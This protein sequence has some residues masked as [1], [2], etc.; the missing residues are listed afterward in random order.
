MVLGSKARLTSLPHPQ[1]DGN[2]GVA[3]YESPSA[4]DQSPHAQTADSA[5]A[6]WQPATYRAAGHAA[7]SLPWRIPNTSAQSGRHGAEAARSSACSRAARVESLT[8]SFPFCL[9]RRLLL[10][11]LT[12]AVDCQLQA[13][14]NFRHDPVE[15]QFQN[16]L[17]G[18]EYDIDRR[19]H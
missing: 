13:A 16:R 2:S 18:M 7:Q 15:R 12:S 3:N 11:R 5:T 4:Q 19:F 14:R 8:S 10:L 17:A 9:A 1:A 6:G